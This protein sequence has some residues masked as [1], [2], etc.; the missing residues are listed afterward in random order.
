MDLRQTKLTRKEWESIEVPIIGLEKEILT[1]IKRGYSNPSYHYNKSLS[2]L[3]YMKL[4]SEEDDK[5]KYDNDKYHVFL[6]NKY[7]KERI[8][9][10]MKKYCVTSITVIAKE[11]K[12]DVLKKADLIRIENT[13][14][15]ISDDLDVYEFV[16]L[17]NC[18]QMLAKKSVKHFYTLTQL[19]KNAI[20][21]LNTYIVEFVNKI[22]EHMGM[23]FE[24]EQIINGAYDVIERNSVLLDYKDYT[25]YKHQQD[26][27]KEIKRP[28][29]K[30]I[31]YQAPTATGK[32]LTPI[33]ICQGY[34][35][36]FVCAAKHVGLQ[37]ARAC[38]SAEVPI[39]VAFGCNDS[40]D[41]RLHY[42][43]AK[44]Y[45]INKKSGG[46][47]KVDNTVGDK[48]QLIVSDVHSYLH[49]MRYMLAFNEKENIVMYWDEPTI[50]LDYDEHPFHSI[51]SANWRENEIPN[52]IL[53]SATL[54]D[55]NEIRDAVSFFENKFDTKNVVAIKSYECKKTI[56]IV[57]VHGFAV[58]PHYL[59][60]D[61]AE[62]MTCVEYC[63]QSQTILRHFDLREICAF[64]LLV[65]KRLRKPRQINNY[66][67]DISEIN[68]E[69]IKL[70]YLDVFGDLETC[71]REVSEEAS[72]IRK[73]KYKST[74]KMVAEDAL[75]LTDGPTLYL[76]DDVDNVAK[77]FFSMLD[78]PDEENKRIVD[79]I[80]FNN[81]V[82]E[83]IH[84]LNDE[85][86]NMKSEETQ[87]GKAGV[88][89]E[90]DDFKHK[91]T[92]KKEE[93]LQTKEKKT[94]YDDKIQLI[95]TLTSQ[96]KRVHMNRRYIPNTE[97]H[98]ERFHKTVDSPLNK[99]SSRVMEKDVEMIMA[100]DDLDDVY[101]ML[102]IAGIGVFKENMSTDYL[103]IMKRLAYNQALFMIIA[104]GDYI[105]G[106]NYQFCHGYIDD[107][108]TQE[109]LIQ[110]F[111]RIGRTNN[112][113]D[114]SIRLTD[115]RT[116]SKI[117]KH[118][119]NKREVINMNRLFSM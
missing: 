102:L 70:Y 112:Q 111:G 115:N 15:K 82:N 21:N 92:Q 113:L 46:I 17:A 96:L 69:S 48:V 30:L 55:K 106:T 81:R 116:I 31:F 86:N 10:M 4:V 56:P 83:R 87:G 59:Y 38:I 7:F 1:L 54:P 11:S 42:F 77:K 18:Q 100:I 93:R 118:E 2:L 99:F 114:Y 78:V 14:K 40:E 104:G 101:K 41:V 74:S 67:D 37:L 3:S 8:E 89:D 58:L 119:P 108:M 50:T 105:Y 45:T 84:V 52:V 36:I 110:A 103:E 49:A 24:N 90:N 33:G 26:V 9:K 76:C 27:F 80:E 66:F 65:N 72:N 88:S 47:G 98:M 35:V 22:M 29:A 43:A 20:Y 95:E 13:N 94:P 23:E 62:L 60:S 12:K 44:E 51:L 57:D 63:R 5:K 28:G 97:Q 39:G 85:I 19:M 73:R 107:A 61:Y 75:T 79:I 6:F 117:L 68:V 34:K 16:L 53:S 25:L 91:K 109:K 71:W 32:T 64:L